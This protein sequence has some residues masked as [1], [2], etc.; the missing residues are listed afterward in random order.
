M[1]ILGTVKKTVADQMVA[2]FE[3]A[4][5]KRIY[6]LVGDSL[7]GFTDSLR[8]AKTIEW[9]HVRHEEVAAFAA[10]AEAWKFRRSRPCIP[11]R[12]RPLIPN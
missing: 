3:A 6:G 4:G 12:S 10:G 9:L 5:V 11:K 1:G 7:N 8:R 2:T